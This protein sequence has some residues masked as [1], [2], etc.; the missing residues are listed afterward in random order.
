MSSKERGRGWSERL[1]R[2]A[3]LENNLSQHGTYD[4]AN[5]R[6]LNIMRSVR[7][8]CHPRCWETCSE[9]QFVFL[10]NLRV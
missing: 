8:L 2:F 7:L 1:K 4:V 3:R 10:L 6:G 5:V 9:W